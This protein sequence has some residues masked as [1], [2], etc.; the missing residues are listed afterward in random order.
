MSELADRLNAALAGRYRVERE[1]GRGGMGT[2]FLA[3]DLKHPRRVAIKVLLPELAVAVGAERFQRE[4]ELAAGLSHPHIMAL[5]ESGA[6]HGL[7]Y[8]VMPYAEGESLRQRLEREKQLPL[9][10]ALRIA[11]EVAGALDFAHRRGIVHRDIKPENILSEDGHAVLA[12]FGIARAIQTAGGEKLTATGVSIGT[13]D[14]M[15]PEQGAG[16]AELDGRSDL[17][18]LACVLYEMLAGNPPFTGSNPWAIQARH[19]FDPVPPLRT[20]RPG[21]P[22]AIERAVTKALAKAPADRH[23]TAAEFAEALAAATEVAPDPRVIRRRRQRAAVAWL[24][25]LALAGLAVW[26]RWDSIQAFFGTRGPAPATRKEWVIVAEFNGPPDDPGLAAATRELVIAALDQST[27]LATVSQDQIRTG[28]QLAGKSP[29][30]RVD[31]ALA[32]ELAYRKGVRAVVEGSISR[33]GAGSAIVARVLDVE[34]D[35]VLFTVSEVAANEKALIPT[36]E[37]VTRRIREGL[38]ERKDAIRRTRDVIEVSTASLEALKH[39]QQAAECLVAGDNSGTIAHCRAAIALDPDFAAAFNAMGHAFNNSG[40][41]DS[42]SAAWH[43]AL[44]RPGRLSDRMRLATEAALATLENDLPLALSNYDRILQQD[45]RLWRIHN[46]RAALLYRT[47]QYEAALAS[48]A[49]G[50][51]ASPMGPSQIVLLNKFITLL[52]LGRLDEA[53]ETSRALR[54]ALAQG[55]AV[56]LAA[57]AGHWALTESLGTAL[58]A[59]PTA[60]REMRR[61]GAL[62]VASAAATRGEVRVAERALRRAEEFEGPGGATSTTVAHVSMQAAH[63][64]RLLLAQASGAFP[65][66]PEGSWPR[67]TATAALVTRG[68]WA[69]AAGDIPQARRLLDAVR[70]RPARERARAGADS[71]L[72]EGW[73]AAHAGRWEDVVWILAPAAR[74]GSEVGFMEDRAGRVTLRWLV[75]NAYENLGR[76]DSAAAYYEMV[77]SPLGRVDQ[78]YFTRGVALS[79][80]HRRL[81]L[82]YARMG[83]LEDARRHWEAFS[84]TFTRPDPGMKPQVEEARA[85]LASAEGMAKSARR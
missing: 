73:I 40:Q 11:R 57:A 58:E 45:P 22:D 42:A 50:I 6:T 70:S 13:P 85:A 28:L 25:A 46:N 60:S 41:V 82:L 71:L 72:L 55:A 48:A 63:R 29:T 27:S 33:L 21:V 69:A 18:A 68:L 47:G 77:L 9:P 78:E 7:L 2:V 76:A 32:R 54:D 26:S 14:Y 10:D 20:V 84:K 37:R 36:V 83:R 74:Q 51:E 53:G 65:G 16:S 19:A 67:D 17:Y 79:F 23:A 5:H 59:P 61:L 1:L 12:D 62:A 56:W 80:A 52:A 35:S 81:V 31:A 38:G 30:T 43:Q 24:A 15:S 3:Q 39:Q 8:F 75:A 49:R 64:A 66:D 4:I 44:S 34:R